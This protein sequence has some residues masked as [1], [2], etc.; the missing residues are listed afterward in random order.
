VNRLQRGSNASNAYGW[1]KFDT[2]CE[3]GKG[4]LDRYCLSFVSPLL[5]VVSMIEARENDRTSGIEASNL[6]SQGLDVVFGGMTRGSE[7]KKSVSG[8]TEILI[9]RTG[10]HPQ[11][12]KRCVISHGQLNRSHDRGQM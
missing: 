9:V 7:I 3:W 6:Q 1:N 4:D 5:F 2:R 11:T 10:G 8:D 12:L